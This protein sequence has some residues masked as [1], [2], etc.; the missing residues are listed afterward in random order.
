MF[1]RSDPRLDYLQ[2][3]GPS[4]FVQLRKI[5][6]VN[7]NVKDC[8]SVPL[9]SGPYLIQKG[10]FLCRKSKTEVVGYKVHLA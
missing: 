6:N 5:T 8:D 10:C 2:I 1:R 4:P 7:R 9:C 3:E